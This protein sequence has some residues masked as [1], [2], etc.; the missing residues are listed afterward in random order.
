[1]RPRPPRSTPTDTIFPYTTPFRSLPLE[2]EDRHERQRDDQQAEE[3]GWAD[4]G[5]RI[6]DDRPA[7][8]VIELLAGM[9]L[10]PMLD[11]LEIGRAHVELQSIMRISYPAF[12]LKKKTT[13][14]TPHEK[15]ENTITI[16]NT[17]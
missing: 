11:L 14:N 6:G 7:L 8:I 2:R 15:S 9:I 16:T 4:L 13:M 10:L 3:K 17:Y 12:C 1:M 5:G